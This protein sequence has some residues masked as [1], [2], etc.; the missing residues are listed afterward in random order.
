[1]ASP[2]PLKATRAAEQAAMAAD[3]PPSQPLADPP[4]SVILPR[5]PDSRSPDELVIA[6]GTALRILIRQYGWSWLAPGHLR[7]PGA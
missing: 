2:R 6:E 5:V 4:R 3:L 1:M 7:R